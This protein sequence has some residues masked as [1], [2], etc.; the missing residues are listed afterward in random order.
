MRHTLEGAITRDA[1]AMA[2]QDRR[3]AA[4]CLSHWDRRSQYASHDCKALL[5]AN[6]MIP[7]MSRTGDRWDN[8]V[9]ESFFATL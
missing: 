8:A 5:M 9:A 3:P 2:L 1:L 4:G 7:S 6:D